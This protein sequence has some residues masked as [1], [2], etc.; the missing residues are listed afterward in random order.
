MMMGEPMVRKEMYMNQRRMRE[1]AMPMF[2]P[3]PEHTPKAFHSIN[4]LIPDN[5]RIAAFSITNLIKLLDVP[6]TKI[7][8]ATQLYM[9]SVH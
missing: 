4:P 1:V 3:K 8:Q 2:S 6:T 5:K 9:L 7:A